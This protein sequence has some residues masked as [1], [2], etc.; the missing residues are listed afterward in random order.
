[1]PASGFAG[2]A[3]CNKKP[4]PVLNQTQGQDTNTMFLR[5]HL[6]CPA[7]RKAARRRAITP[8]PCNGGCRLRLLKAHALF[9]LP[10]AVHLPAP[11]FALFHHPGSLLMR[12]AVLSPPHRFNCI[13]HFTAVKSRANLKIFCRNFSAAQPALPFPAAGRNLRLV[14]LAGRS[15]NAPPHGRSHAGERFVCTAAKGTA[16]TRPRPSARAKAPA[17]RRPAA[18]QSA[19]AVPVQP[20]PPA[21]RGPR[22]ASA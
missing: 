17:H 18:R 16:L 3:F 1:M 14:D 22:P 19:A 12:Y 21:A 5:C 2:R 9:T 20:R 13:I 6:V 8:L 4:V 15:A 7:L 10:S 11:L